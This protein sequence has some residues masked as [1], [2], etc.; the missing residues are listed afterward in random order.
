MK[1]FQ[2]YFRPK[3]ISPFFI[4]SSVIILNVVPFL[5]QFFHFSF[6]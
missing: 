6:F 4:V 2:N 5:G 1:K 3:I